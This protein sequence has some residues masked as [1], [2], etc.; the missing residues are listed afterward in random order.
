MTCAT[1]DATNFHFASRSSN[2][3]WANKAEFE[4]CHKFSNE[5][6]CT[7]FCEINFF[8]FA[9]TLTKVCRL[10]CVWGHQKSKVAEELCE[11]YTDCNYTNYVWIVWDTSTS[12][13]WKLG[14]LLWVMQS[15]I[16]MSYDYDSRCRGRTTMPLKILSRSEWRPNWDVTHSVCK[17]FERDERAYRI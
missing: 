4:F 1:F 16:T 9:F 13:P 2:Q 14:A 10:A 11:P 17:H 15:F 3:E 5:K 6:L 7:E 12:F 8:F